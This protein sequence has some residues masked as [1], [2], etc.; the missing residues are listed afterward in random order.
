M[1]KW[2]VTPSDNVVRELDAV[3]KVVPVRG[4][5]A[6]LSVATGQQ[7]A[8]VVTALVDIVTADCAHGDH[9]YKS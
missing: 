1:T 2:L 3:P 5:V 8:E 9:V 4:D 6:S 7:K